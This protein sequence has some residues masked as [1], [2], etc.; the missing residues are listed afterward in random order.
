MRKQYGNLDSHPFVKYQM[1]D[2][3]Y[4]KFFVVLHGSGSRESLADGE[5]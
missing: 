3:V 4:V 2:A 5:L 1:M